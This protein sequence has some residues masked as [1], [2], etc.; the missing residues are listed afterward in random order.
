MKKFLAVALV[1]LSFSV[2]MAIGFNVASSVDPVKNVRP[3][4]DPGSI[5][6]GDQHNLLIVQVDEL[7]NPSPKLV[8]VWFVS[9]F[10]LDG[11]PPTLTFAQLYSPQA[12]TPR[13]LSLGR[14]FEITHSSEIGA[15]FWKAV[16]QFKVQWEGYFLVDN[17]SVQRIMEWI[18]GPGNFAEDLNKSGQSEATILQACHMAS[19]LQKGTAVPF[20]WTGLAPDHFRS[21]LRM[22]IGLSYWDR[23]MQKGLPL[24]CEILLA[25]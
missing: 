21:N 3:T 9:L 5:G 22:E 11:A 8:S 2:C 12:S 25:P 20:D 4:A 6:K 10:F 14:A 23:M 17:I 13:A 15:G 1:I 7:N 18:N 16:Q 24:R 19:N